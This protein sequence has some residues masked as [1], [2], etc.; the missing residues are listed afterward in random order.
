MKSSMTLKIGQGVKSI[1]I[2][3]ER[4]DDRGGN[5]DVDM[6]MGPDGITIGRETISW[7]DIDGFREMVSGREKEGEY[8]N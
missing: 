1:T 6:E 7:E 5:A 2:T 8:V 3:F 4:T